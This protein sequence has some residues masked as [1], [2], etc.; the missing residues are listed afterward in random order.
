[1]RSSERRDRD[2]RRELD[3]LRRAIVT[4]PT[5]LVARA[6]A[7]IDKVGQRSY[8]ESWAT[9]P[10]AEL[11]AEIREE[12]A[13]LPGWSVLTAQRLDEL[14]PASAAKIDAHL[15]AVVE[16]AGRADAE[17]QAIERLLAG[18]GGE[19]QAAAA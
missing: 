13:D 18:E 15:A 17:A 11:V 6:L 10:I 4:D 5:G 7:R 19:N 3:W 14:D 9:R 16:Y 2:R 1:M 12:C 8:G